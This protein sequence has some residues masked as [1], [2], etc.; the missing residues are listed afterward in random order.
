MPGELYDILV[1]TLLALLWL[2]LA[3][4]SSPA[5]KKGDTIIYMHV[6]NCY[7]NQYFYCFHVEVV[8]TVELYERRGGGE[9]ISE[10]LEGA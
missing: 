3:I 9:L 7:T 1:V 5:E 8:C 10:T 4:L 6:R 2:G